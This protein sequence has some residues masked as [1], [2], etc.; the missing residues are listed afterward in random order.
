M[1]VLQPPER[2]RSTKQWRR[3]VTVFAASFVSTAV[4]LNAFAGGHQT[5][6]MVEVI[7]K[8]DDLVGTA[9]SANQG[10]VTR[11]QLENR[12]IL[13]PAEVVETVP[14]VIV[15][16]HSGDGKANQYFLRGF[17]LDHGTDLATTVAGMPVNMPTHAH[18]Q[19]YTDLNFLIPELVAGVQY[20]K[21][22]Y[23]ADQGDF[24]TAGAGNISYAST[25]D[26]P[27]LHIE[28]GTYDFSRGLFAASPRVG[29]GNLLL[30]GETST[31][32][33]PWTV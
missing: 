31:N 23:F 7:G 28:A 21:G 17:N 4:T 10:T 24:A 30:A 5:L 11:E 18:G 9:D 33:G 15:T 27:L 19:G 20:S 29:K 26:R 1:S 14:G 12:P 22:P 8:R 6:E 16:Q 13:R 3:A 2:M 32:S 25:L